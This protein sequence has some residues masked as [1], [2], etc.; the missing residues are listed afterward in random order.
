VASSEGAAVM[1]RVVPA[2]WASEAAAVAEP[3]GARAVSVRAR[4]V[5][6]GA[7]TAVKGRA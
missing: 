6:V 4:T 5:R 3:S 2:L 1:V 7:R